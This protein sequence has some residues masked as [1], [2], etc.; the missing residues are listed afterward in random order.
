F[1]PAALMRLP[2]TTTTALRTTAPPFTSTMRAARMAVSGCGGGAGCC[3]RGGC[4]MS[5]GAGV[6]RRGDE[7]VMWGGSRWRR[8]TF[9]RRSAARKRWRSIL[10]MP[11]LQDI[12]PRTTLVDLVYLGRDSFIA[13]AFLDTDDG[14]AI[15]DPGPTVSMPAVKEALAMRGRTLGDVRA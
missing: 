12:A 3:A 6:Q 2:S 1:A 11:V 5:A 10:R 7:G 13:S 9:E 8:H 14:I 4:A 15:I